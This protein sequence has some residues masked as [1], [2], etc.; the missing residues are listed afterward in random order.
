MP[1]TQGALAWFIEGQVQDD[2]Y[3]DKLK[4]GPRRP[5]KIIKVHWDEQPGM[6]AGQVN[7]IALIKGQKITVQNV[8]IFELDP[9]SHLDEQGKQR[10]SEGY[11]GAYALLAPSDDLPAW[12]D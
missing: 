2:Q 6:K 7:L 4:A 8:P 12:T 9:T 1:A 10:Y 5:A 11:P 3:A